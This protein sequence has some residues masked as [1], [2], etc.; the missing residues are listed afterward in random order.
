MASWSAIDETILYVSK[1]IAP[2]SVPN[3][4]RMGESV[5]PMRPNTAPKVELH[6]MSLWSVIHKT[7]LYV[8]N[9]IASNGQLN[10]GCSGGIYR[11]NASENPL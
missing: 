9:K 2:N 10:I 6:S 1:N 8:Q 4:T 5:G 3:I 11:D 7:I